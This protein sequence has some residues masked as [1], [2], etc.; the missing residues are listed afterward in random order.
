MKVLP[1]MPV[2]I[3]AADAIMIV[4]VLIDESVDIVKVVS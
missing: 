2:T 3:V 4:E 1:S